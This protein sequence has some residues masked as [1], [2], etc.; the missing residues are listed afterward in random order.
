MPT[1]ACYLALHPISATL[2]VAGA[3]ILG[4]AT[5]VTLVVKTRLLTRDDL[6]MVG[7][8]A[9]IHPPRATSGLRA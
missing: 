5:Y 3:V 2:S 9:P 8:R 4:G 6:R 7:R 1:V